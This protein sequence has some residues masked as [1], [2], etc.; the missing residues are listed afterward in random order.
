MDWLPDFTGRSP[1]DIRRC[2]EEHDAHIATQPGVMTRNANEIFAFASEISVGDLVVLP[3]RPRADRFAAGVVIAPY[4][5]RTDWVSDARHVV[6]VDWRAQEIRR[7]L[8]T[9]STRSQ[10]QRRQ[11]VS[12][13]SAEAVQ[14]IHGLLEKR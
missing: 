11:T 14:E 4:T 2:L 10:L 6:A 12:K 13:L 8:L 3:R 5:F 9:D 7:D 1:E